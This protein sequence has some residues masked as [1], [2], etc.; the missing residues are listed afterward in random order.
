MLTLCWCAHVALRLLTMCQLWKLQPQTQAEFFLTTANVF[1]PKHASWIKPPQKTSIVRLTKHLPSV[2]FHDLQ[3]CKP[4]GRSIKSSD[5]MKQRQFPPYSSSQEQFDFLLLWVFLV[6][7]YFPSTTL[8]CWG[9]NCSFYFT[10]LFENLISSYF[11]DLIYLMMNGYTV[12]GK[13][14][15]E[16]RDRQ[17]QILP[18]IGHKPTKTNTTEND[19]QKNAQHFIQ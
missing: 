17:W 8:Y 9:K 6:F 12:V 1:L 15:C 7:L 14:T 19:N 4:E 11:A 18:E 13:L 2:W 5:T 16:T 3:E 10:T